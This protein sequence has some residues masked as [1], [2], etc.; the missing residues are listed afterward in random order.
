[1]QIIVEH[2]LHALAS[3]VTMRMVAHAAVRGIEI[4]ELES[5]LE[6]D[7]D[8]SGFFRPST[9]VSSTGSKWIFRSSPNRVYR[10]GS[11]IHGSLAHLADSSDYSSLTFWSAQTTAES[12]V[13]LSAPRR[14]SVPAI[15]APPADQKNANAPQTPVAPMISS[16]HAK[17]T[18]I[19][20]P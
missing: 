19:P 7:I 10:L 2:L 16:P 8:L 14:L 17:L 1:M 18:P 6:G 13:N 11:A 9:T 3:C 5:E 12:S 4:Q 15:A 20:R